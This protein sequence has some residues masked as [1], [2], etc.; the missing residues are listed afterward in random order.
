[1]SF[2]SFQ[3]ENRILTPSATVEMIHN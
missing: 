3:T 1:M 2:R